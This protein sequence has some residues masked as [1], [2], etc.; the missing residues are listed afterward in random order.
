MSKLSRLS[1]LS[2]AAAVALAFAIADGAPAASES[3][4]DEVAG[5][6]KK[7]GKKKRKRVL[8]RRLNQISPR[9]R[10]QL[11]GNRGPRGKEGPGGLQG[12]QGTQG[13]E[14]PR[15]PAGPSTEIDLLTIDAFW[16]LGG[17][18]GTDPATDFLGTTDEE[19]L[20]LRVDGAAGLLLLPASDGVAASPNVVGGTADNAVDAGT[21]G[22]T[23]AG[24]A[25][26]EAANPASANRVSDDR[27]TVGGG[28]GNRAGDGAGT[29][30]DTANATV[31]GGRSNVAG[32]PGATV[33]GGVSNTATGAPQASTVAGGFSNDATGS[34]SA[35]G[36]GFANEASETASFVGG[37]QVNDASGFE[38]SVLGGL[39]NV[40][41]GQDSAVGGGKENTASG[42]GAM[43]AGGFRNTAAGNFSFVAGRQAAN[44]N[45]AHDGVFIFAD[46]QTEDIAS[47]AADQFIARAGGGFF[48]QD[49]STLDDQG[50]FLNT[51]TGAHLTTGGAWTDSSDVNLKQ[52]FRAVS[53]RSLLARVSKLPV[54]SWSYIAEP[55]VRH[56]GPTAQDFRGAFGLGADN[57]HIAALDANGVALAAIKALRAEN[58]RLSRR[59]K[60]LEAGSVRRLAKVEARMERLERGRRR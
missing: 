48:L 33:G 22:A 15:G 54:R 3:T 44:S 60:R 29:T 23:I 1:A 28:A 13:P 26:A 19:P 59:L 21:F 2:I 24:G 58:R 8:I 12:A 52:G 45:A 51:S 20:E 41:S 38:S 25:R 50:G 43:V 39:N 31:G 47:T 17:N 42:F 49:D 35:I 34:L 18:A 11:R 36:G 14:G 40:A 7:K 6:A 30:S 56:V 9:V 5:A 27:G 16:R 4:D 32:G 37:G 46:S 55:G 10:R 53:P 57:R